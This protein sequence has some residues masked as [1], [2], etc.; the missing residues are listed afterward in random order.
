MTKKISKRDLNL[1]LVLAG[2]AVFLVLYFAGFLKLQ[3]KTETIEAELAQQKT[4]LAG[5]EE[6]YARLPEYEAAISDAKTDI[7][8]T[9]ARIPGGVED[10]DFLVYLTG[11]HEELGSKLT[12]VSFSDAGTVAQ[13]ELPGEGANETFAGCRKTTVSTAT[14]TYPQLKDALD[15]IYGTADITYLDSVAVTYDSESAKLETVFTVSKLYASCSAC[16]Y[17]PSEM[18]EVPHG[19]A[20]L[21]GTREDAPAQD[22]GEEETGTESEVPAE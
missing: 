7:E 15:R 9:L 18:P 12:A 4:V 6:H 21:F 20:D 8:A 11:M 10:E 22:G 3:E 16:E 5:L 2:V 13:F 19:I 1:L 14:M 17:V